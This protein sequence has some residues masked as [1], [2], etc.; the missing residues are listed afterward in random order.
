LLRGWELSLGLNMR[1]EVE[2]WV[3]IEGRLEGS[4]I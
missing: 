1:C 3:N 2:C 4:L